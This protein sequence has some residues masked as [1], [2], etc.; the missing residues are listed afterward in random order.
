MRVEAT[1]PSGTTIRW[2]KVKDYFTTQTELAKYY[3]LFQRK[4]YELTNCNIACYRRSDP[5]DH[6]RSASSYWED[7]FNQML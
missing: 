1:T 7:N 2:G 3:T 4:E 6:L 5:E